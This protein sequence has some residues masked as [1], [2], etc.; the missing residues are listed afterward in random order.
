MYFKTENKHQIIQF[1]LNIPKT[2][3]EDLFR[4]KNLKI[5]IPLI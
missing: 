1:L 4:Q 2:D 5:F 3:L